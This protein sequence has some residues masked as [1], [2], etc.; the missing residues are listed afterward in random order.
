VELALLIIVVDH[1][2]HFQCEFLKLFATFSSSFFF[3]AA[4]DFVGGLDA[5]AIAIFARG[6]VDGDAE[7]FLRVEV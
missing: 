3:F 6:E 4:L 7:G 1:L 2:E 5:F